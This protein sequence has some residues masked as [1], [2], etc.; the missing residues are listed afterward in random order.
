MG[1]FQQIFQKYIFD[2]SIRAG[3]ST[4]TCR[5]SVSLS[6][7]STVASY[8]IVFQRYNIVQQVE[9]AALQYKS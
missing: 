3:Q 6:Y 9:G 4:L 8:S 2:C 1:Y 5:Y 7:I